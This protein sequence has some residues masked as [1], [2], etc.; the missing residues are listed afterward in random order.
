MICHIPETRAGRVVLGARTDLVPDANADPRRATDRV[1]STSSK[2][3]P[4]TDNDTTPRLADINQ[5]LADLAR[6][7]NVPRWTV[8]RSA[9]GLP[10]YAVLQRRFWARVVVIRDV[11]NAI[12]YLTARPTATEDPLKP[13]NTLVRVDGDAITCL[14]ALASYSMSTRANK[15]LTPDHFDAADASLRRFV[16][17]VVALVG[18]S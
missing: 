6:P 10:C 9:G 18:V 11:D 17:N 12:A 13:T 4:V 16:A 5:R 15:D 1:T 2:R 14:K 8:A 7:D 3:H